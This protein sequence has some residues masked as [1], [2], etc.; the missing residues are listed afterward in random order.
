[1][2][3]VPSWGD[4]PKLEPITGKVAQL[5]DRLL[6]EIRQLDTDRL[7]WMDGNRVYLEVGETNKPGS[8]FVSFNDGKWTSEIW[9][10]AYEGAHPMYQPTEPDPECRA[11][12]FR[13]ALDDLMNALAAEARKA[14]QVRA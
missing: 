2:D 9:K 13:E 1:M 6:S 4:I 5:S 3:Q 11:T 12:T 14:G 10:A 8:G 7:S